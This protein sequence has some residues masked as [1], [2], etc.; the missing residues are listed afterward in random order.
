MMVC[1]RVPVPEQR[2]EASWGPGPPAKKPRRDPAAQKVDHILKDDIWA[3]PWVYI[4][5]PTLK[6]LKTSQVWQRFVGQSDYLNLIPVFPRRTSSWE[7]PSTMAVAC[8][9]TPI[10]DETWVQ[11]PP[12]QNPH[13]SWCSRTIHMPGLLW[14][15]NPP[16]KKKKEIPQKLTDQLAYCISCSDKQQR[17]C[18]QKQGGRWGL[19][20]KAVLDIHMPAVATQI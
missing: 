14:W 6:W 17:P 11:T 7:L 2:Q 10:Q 19:T 3:F 4:C 13:K 9:V 18:S 5:N 8:A 12:P 1:T 15:R 20:T 16:E